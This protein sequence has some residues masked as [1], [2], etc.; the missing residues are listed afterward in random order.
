MPTN[1]REICDTL[2]TPGAGTS[3]PA[4]LRAL[5]ESF[6]AG[7]EVGLAI[8]LLTTV[9][10]TTCPAWSPHLETVIEQFL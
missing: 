7:G 5:I 1:A 2:G 10:F 8:G 3:A 9:V 4:A 6:V